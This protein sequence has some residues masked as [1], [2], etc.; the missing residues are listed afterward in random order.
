MSERV[1]LHVGPF[2]TGSTFLQQVLDRNRETLAGSGM[3]LPGG[4]TKAQATAAMDLVGG[5]GRAGARSGAGTGGDGGGAGKGRVRWEQIAEQAR[6]ASTPAAVIS[7]EYLCR[8]NA[9]QARRAATSLQPAEVHL[10]YMARDLSKVIPAMWQTLM[11]NGGS[12]P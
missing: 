5:P 9:R 1:F 2:K 4:D 7:A 12:V 10:V 6:T 11:R 8:A 3:S